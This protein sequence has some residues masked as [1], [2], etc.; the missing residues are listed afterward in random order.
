MRRILAVLLV[1]AGCRTAVAATD[2]ATVERVVDGDTVDVR[3]GDRRERVRLLG[4]DTPEIH[5]ERGP[6]D[7][8]GPE[9]SSFTKALLPTGTPVR[10]ERDVVGRDDY[11]RLLVY[12]YLAADGRMVNEAIVAGGFATPLSIA[13][14]DAYASRFVDAA[15]TAEAAG[16]GLWGACGG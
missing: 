12:V 8:F 7:C 16:L 4:I 6:P 9:A 1:A 10:L 2:Q 13:P 11:G 14:N 5:V 15:T 3:I